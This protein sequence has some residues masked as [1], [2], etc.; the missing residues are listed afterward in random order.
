MLTG[1]FGN[2]LQRGA[3]NEVRDFIERVRE[4]LDHLVDVSY[5]CNLVSFNVMQGLCFFWPV[6]L[7]EGDDQHAFQL[8]S[9]LISVLK[10]S[11]C[12]SEDEY[13]ASCEEFTT[14]VVDERARHSLGGKN[15]ED[16]PDIVHY[17][18]ADYNFLSR[19]HLL[20]VLKL[21][22][23]VTVQRRKSYPIVS[24]ELDGSAVNPAVL[25]SCIT[26]V[27]SY[28]LSPCYKQKSFFT[29]STMEAVR[30]A[31]TGS[32]AF[33]SDARFDPW[34]GLLSGDRDAFVKQY[35]DA[36]TSFLTG[37]KKDSYQYLCGANRHSSR[38]VTGE[39][40]ENC[41]CVSGEKLFAGARAASSKSARV[42][43]TSKSRPSVC[44]THSDESLA[45]LLKKKG[46]CRKGRISGSRSNLG[47]KQL[48]RCIVL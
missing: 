5:C 46:K 23:L 38:A 47:K 39:L 21:C 24:F 45:Q 30:D 1:E 6:I 28:V 33:L 22:C 19:R 48:S 18:L 4:F 10:K 13:V 3:T 8:F 25:S 9:K 41:S 2:E 42:A 29:Q 14:Y 27:Q 34:D 44:G 20:R 7:L 36:F 43:G 40:S 35:D 12:L 15:A 37:N 16:I 26:E 11:G 32:R 31:I 17:L